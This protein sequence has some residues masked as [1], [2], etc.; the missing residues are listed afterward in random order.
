MTKKIFLILGVLLL[1]GGAALWATEGEPDFAAIMESLDLRSKFE[2]TDFSS[3]LTIITED[4][5][6]GVDKQIL[7]QFR[8]DDADEFLMITLQPLSKK[9]QGVLIVEDNAWIYDPESRKF[10]HMSLKENY[11]DTDAKM[12]DFGATSYAED[13][14]VARYT[15]GKLGDYHVWIVEWEAVNDEVP[16]PYVT[17]YIDKE[18]ELLLMTREYSLSKRL[19]RSSYFL[20]YARIGEKYISTR[21]IFKDETMDNAK[22]TITISSVSLDEVDDSIF[23]KSYLERVNR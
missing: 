5:E 7:N 3:R 17:A 10:T 20:K 12:N 23:T 22:T 1:A 16:Y 13:Y 15:E 6:E 2:G 21:M 9:G 4:P 8:N 11:E 19:L 14:E 18:S